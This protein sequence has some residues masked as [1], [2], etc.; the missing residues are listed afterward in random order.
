MSEKREINK[1]Y[2]EIDNGVG[3]RRLNGKLLIRISL[4]FFFL[5]F[6]SPPP[7]PPPLRVQ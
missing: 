5:L 7:P 1:K 2:F 6:F 4:Y 3:G